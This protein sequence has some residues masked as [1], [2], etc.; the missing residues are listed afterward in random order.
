MVDKK[1]KFTVRIDMD[2]KNYK[3]ELGKIYR[4]EIASNITECCMMNGYMIDDIDIP[5][6]IETSIHMKLKPI[7]VIA[8]NE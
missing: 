6:E 8:D 1:Y 3:L 4:M 5:N 7:K 2:V